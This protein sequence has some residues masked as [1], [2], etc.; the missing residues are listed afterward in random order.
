MLW[1]AMKRLAKSL[2]DS[3]WAASLVGPKIFRPRARK[4]LTTPAASGASGPT[5]V[6]WI[7]FCS[8]KSARASGS[9]RLR[10]SSSCSRA[11]PALPGAT[12]TFCRPGVLARR[13]A[14]ACSRPP[15]PITSSFMTDLFE[16]LLV[17]EVTVAGEH[18]GQAMLVGGGD[19]FLVAHRTARLDDGLG[20]GFSHH[21]DAVAEREE[22]VR[23]DDRTGQ[24]QA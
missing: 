1:R 16:L 12:Y 2:E 24:V 20:T 22:G 14:M 13:Q 19:D 17:A 5:T 6:R 21:V 7:L 3:S 4:T 10:F 18:H 9:V 8:A 15:E 11:V 23:G